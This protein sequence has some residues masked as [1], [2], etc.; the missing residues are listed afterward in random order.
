M[1]SGSSAGPIESG[2][3]IGGNK[4][5]IINAEYLVPLVPEAK[6]KAV[7]FFDAGRAFDDSETVPLNNLHLR[8]G[9][10]M[11]IR[12]ISP[13]G[14]L[15]LE[16]GYNLKPRENERHSNVDFTIGTLF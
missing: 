5:L 1:S 6:I 4:E 10:G 11:G 12:W 15:R 13:I 9:T 14:P 16:W 8:Y 7:F 3:I 2:E